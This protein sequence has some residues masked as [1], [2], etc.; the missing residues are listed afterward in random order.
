MILALLARL[1]RAAL[2][3]SRS[4]PLACYLGLTYGVSVTTFVNFFL[5]FISES[6][7]SVSFRCP[8]SS[9]T[10]FSGFRSL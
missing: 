8:L 7:K 1:T 4:L 3:F 6:P 5:I 9:S 10:K 2:L